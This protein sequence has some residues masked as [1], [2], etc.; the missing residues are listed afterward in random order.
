MVR[1]VSGRVRGRFL[2]LPLLLALAACGPLRTAPGLNISRL[3]PM[4]GLAGHGAALAL[5]AHLSVDQ[6]AQQMLGHLSLDDKLGQLIIMQFTEQ[7]YTPTQAAMIQPY[8]P[9][10][11]ILYSYA[12]GSGDQLKSLLASAQRDSP[13]PMLTMTDLEGGWIDHLAEYVGPHMSAPEMAATGDPGVAT[14]QGAKVAHDLLSFGFN[15]DLAPD[16]DVELVAGPD[17]IGRDFGTTPAPVVTYAGAFLQGLQSAGV[18]GTL[19][20]FPGLGDATTDAHADL[21]VINRSRAD[22]E[23]TELAPYRALI[24]SGQAQMI[25][26]TDVLMPALDPTMPAELSRPIVTGILRD[27]L[28]FNGVA[29]TDA[30]YMAGIQDKYYFSQ[31][32]VMAIEAGNDMIMAPFTP[33]MI[34]DVI[35][36]LKAALDSGALTMDQINASVERIL[37]LKLRYHLLPLPA[38]AAPGPVAGPPAA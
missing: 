16:V 25:M 26:S 8:H 19:K 34:G 4:R 37:A 24:A 36:G 20:H 21:P 14:A 31:A 15:A 18:I 7:T 6:V 22:L 28:H 29:I 11:A 38:G 32:A 5:P 9:G 10:G 2:L 12:M 35:A 33:G 30:L 17:Q 1:S 23:A 13:I 3:D 27:E